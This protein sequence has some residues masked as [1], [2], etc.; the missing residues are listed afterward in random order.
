MQQEQLRFKS[1]LIDRDYQIEQLM[2][3]LGEKGEETGRLAEQLIDLKN[4]LL[5]MSLFEE[6]WHVTL[7]PL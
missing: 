4:H 1:E 7:V 3:T 2:T 5:D 6:T